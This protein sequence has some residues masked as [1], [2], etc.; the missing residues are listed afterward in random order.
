MDTTVT[1]RE[2]MLAAAEELHTQAEV[3]A[4]AYDAQDFDEAV[5]AAQNALNRLRAIV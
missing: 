3:I 4:S 1:P 2:E 5:E